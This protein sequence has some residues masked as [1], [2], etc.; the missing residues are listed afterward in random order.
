MVLPHYP[1]KPPGISGNKIYLTLPYSCLFS[2]SIGVRNWK[3]S[4]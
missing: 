1:D 2:A 3:V 4:P